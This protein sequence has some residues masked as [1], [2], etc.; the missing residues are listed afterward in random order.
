MP[1]EVYMARGRAAASES[2]GQGLPAH[3]AC[4]ARV[5]VGCAPLHQGEAH[6][7][8]HPTQAPEASTVERTVLAAARNRLEP[9]P[10]FLQHVIITHRLP[11]AVRIERLIAEMT[12]A[13]IALANH[14]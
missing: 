12:G 5:C 13:S 7:L 11:A 14:V 8:V 2:G 3:A 4:R 6:E 10:V 9:Q 1:R